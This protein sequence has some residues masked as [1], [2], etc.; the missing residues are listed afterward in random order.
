MGTTIYCNKFIE[1]YFDYELLTHWWYSVTNE[2]RDKMVGKGEFSEHLGYK[3]ESN[4]INMWE[5]HVDDHVSF[6]TAC[7]NQPFWGFLSVCKPVDKKKAMIFG[8]DEV[9]M[10]QYLLHMFA[11]T[12]PDGSQPLVPKDNGMGV[13]ISAF[14]SRELGFGFQMSPEMLELINATRKG[15]RYSDE[16]AE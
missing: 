1:R 16:Q 7:T 8:Q 2:K 14:T 5:F 6:Q 9:I 15:K 4:G 12:L 3:Y 13:M 11:W 10:K